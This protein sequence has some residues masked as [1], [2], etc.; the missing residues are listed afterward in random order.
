MSIASTDDGDAIDFESGQMSLK[1]KSRED[2]CSVWESIR[3]SDS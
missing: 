3:H 1:A 2:R